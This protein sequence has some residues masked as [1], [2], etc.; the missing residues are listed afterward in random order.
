MDQRCRMT[1]ALAFNIILIVL[2]FQHSALS[3][4]SF[5]D[6]YEIFLIKTIKSVKYF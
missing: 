5:S 3:C 2:S 1:R 4:L 6:F